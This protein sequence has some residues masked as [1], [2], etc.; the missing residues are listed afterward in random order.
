MS[1]E[2]IS[3]DLFPSA[4][5]AFHSQMR[6]ND[7]GIHRRGPELWNEI[8]GVGWNAD[9][10]FVMSC[11]DQMTLSLSVLICSICVISFHFVMRANDGGIH[12]RGTRA[13]ER[14]YRA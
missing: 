5:S 13:L 1:I 4:L 9:D 2:L 3:V 8:S 11:A 6:A 14:G 12:R 7:G 10:V